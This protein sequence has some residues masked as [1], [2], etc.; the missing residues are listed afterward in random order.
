MTKSQEQLTLTHKVNWR[1]SKTLLGVCLC[2][3]LNEISH[4]F[5]YFCSSESLLWKSY[6]ERESTAALSS[7]SLSWVQSFSN[8]NQTSRWK[9]LMSW[10]W[11]SASSG[12]CSSWIELWTLQLGNMA[13]H[14]VFRRWASSCPGIRCKLSKDWWSTTYSVQLMWPWQRWTSLLCVPTHNRS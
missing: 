9:K 4:I 1:F 5:L 14:G 12:N 2:G 6:V 3:L 11:Q 10:R 8:S 13:I 7:S